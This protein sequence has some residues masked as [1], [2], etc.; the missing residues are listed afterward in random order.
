[1]DIGSPLAT[2]V[3]EPLLGGELSADWGHLFWTSHR[4][5]V[6]IYGICTII[7]FVLELGC[8]TNVDTMPRM[9][10]KAG[11]FTKGVKDFRLCL[12]YLYVMLC[13]VAVYFMN[14]SKSG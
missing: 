4:L 11:E 10:P 9:L 14:Q 3:P 13:A 12:D 6:N 2:Q 5:E 8:L 7:Q 1:M